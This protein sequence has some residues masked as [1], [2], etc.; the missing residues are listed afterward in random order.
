VL[1]HG[2]DQFL[3][4]HSRRNSSILTNL[5]KSGW[6]S[7]ISALMFWMSKRY[8]SLESYF[9]W[10]PFYYYPRAV[11]AMTLIVVIALIVL[12]GDSLFF[13][14]I[15]IVTV[16][17]PFIGREGFTLTAVLR[18]LVPFIFSVTAVVNSPSTAVPLLLLLVHIACIISISSY[19]T[20]SKYQHHTSIIRET[21]A[22]GYRRCS[23]STNSHSRD[24]FENTTLEKR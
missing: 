6:I 24:R 15:R 13:D 18:S 3:D 11:Y 10:T 12:R 23:D 1:I 14:F 17:N 19:S 4:H 9:S 22:W 7:A 2:S 16:D 5:T 20:S 21:N 8:H